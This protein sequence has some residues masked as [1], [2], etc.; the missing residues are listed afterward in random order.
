MAQE[1]S[2]WNG[3]DNIIQLVDMGKTYH[4]ASG[5]VTALEDISLNIRRGSVQGIIGLSG[6][7]KST[8]VR[9]INYLEV[10]TTGKVLFEGRSLGEMSPKDVRN[11][12]REMGMIFQQFNLLDQRNLLQNVMFPL[13]IAKVDRKKARLR[14]MELLSLVGLADRARNYPSQLSGGQKQRVAIA[15]ALATNPKV[16]LCDEATSALDPKTTGQILE[17]LRKINQEMKVTVIIITHQMS[18]I[19]A[20]CDQV[21]IID[22]SHIVES[23]PVSEIF[24]SPKTEIGRRLIFGDEVR[25]ETFGRNRKIRIVFDG[26]NSEE[27]FLANMILTLK[28]TVNILH[29]NM[30]DVGGQ[31]VGQMV[32]ELPEEREQADKIT[33]YLASRKMPFEEVE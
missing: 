32:I 1:I 8:L 21:A 13:E 9:C 12:R 24:S 30:K 28:T 22:H 7:G 27:P 25:T 31:A 33:A 26:R 5:D 2:S 20:V 23:G 17:L 16:L 14:A 19:E 15:R 29:A 4:T 10:P 6:A 3:G 18:V 11:I